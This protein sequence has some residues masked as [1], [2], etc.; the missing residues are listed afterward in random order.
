LEGLS[1]ILPLP[2]YLIT[3]DAAFRAFVRPK[4]INKEAITVD[5]KEAIAS[6]LSI[7]RYAATTIPAEH[8]QTLF[9]ALQLGASGSNRQNWEFIFVGDADLKRDLISACDNQRFVGDCAYFIAAVA[10][11]G[12][13]WHMVDITIALTN[14]TLQATELGYGTCWIGAF[15]E[16]AVKLMLGVPAEKKVV[17]CMAFGQPAGRHV[18]RGRKALEDFIYL[19]HYGRPWPHAG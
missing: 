7:R 10:N 19:D 12:L 6:R 17:V 4:T 8:L 14:F 9:R 5:V 11:P 18:A 2:F 13:K 3:K 16:D 15:D 1:Q